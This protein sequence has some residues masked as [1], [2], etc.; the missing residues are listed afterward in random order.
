MSWWQAIPAIASAAGGIIGAKEKNK[1]SDESL[2]IQRDAY[3]RALD[4]IQ[5]G[6]LSYDPAQAGEIGPSQAALAQ[7]DPQAQ[8]A[9]QG[10]LHELGKASQEGYS[11]IDRAAVNRILAETGQQERGNREAALSRL[12][13]GSG[14]AIAARLS[15]QQSGANRASQQ[16]MDVAAQ[17]RM[18]ALEALG[19]YGGLS[20]NMRNQGFNEDFKRGDAQDAIAR[21]NAETSRFNAGQANAASQAGINNRLAG[22]GVLQ[23][24][25]NALTNGL[26]GRGQDAFNQAAGTGY[27]VGQAGAAIGEGLSDDEDPKKKK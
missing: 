21:F 17:S 25:T 11:D 16:A 2:G 6:T 18:R 1:Y 27:A 8:L 7:G 10:A 19:A 24:S 20:T 9:Q 4:L 13:P 26:L 23:G 15:A 5:G 14:A 22:A 3:Q 12:D